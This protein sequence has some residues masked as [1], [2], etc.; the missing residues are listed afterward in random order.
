GRVDREIGSPILER[1]LELLHEQALAADLSERAVEDLIAARGHSENAHLAFRMDASQ[2]ACD[3]LRLPHG[4][5][6]LA[7]CDH[8]AFGGALQFPLLIRPG[9]LP[10]AI[11]C[12]SR[13]ASRQCPRVS[14]TTRLRPRFRRR[15]RTRGSSAGRPGN[16]D[17]CAGTR[18][19]T[20]A[21]SE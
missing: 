12:G 6:A 5:P 1:R 15:A 20:H 16:C 17:G 8:D 11:A 21:R 7:R 13:A 2:L 18:C 14:P 4:E 19:Q 3:M 10:G 9:L